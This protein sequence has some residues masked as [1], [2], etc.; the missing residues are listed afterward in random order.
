MHDVRLYHR[1]AVLGHGAGQGRLAAARHPVWRHRLHGLVAGTAYRAC[2]AY[3]GPGALAGVNG[4]AAVVHLDTGRKNRGG[5]H[6][7]PPHGTARTELATGAGRGGGGFEQA[8][9]AL[10]L[11]PGAPAGKNPCFGGGDGTPTPDASGQHRNQGTGCG[12]Q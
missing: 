3:A 1:P 5:H 8:L 11:R 12:H 9:P 10:R 2:A 6:F 4:G 7:G